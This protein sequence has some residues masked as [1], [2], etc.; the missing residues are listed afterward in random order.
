MSDIDQAIDRLSYAIQHEEDRKI[1]FLTGSGLS[2]PEV[3]S[4]KAMVSIFLNEV[5]NDPKLKERVRTLSESDQ[6]QA[7]AREV[8]RRRGD[9]GLAAA[10]GKGVLQA[11]NSDAISAGVDPESIKDTDWN[12]PVAQKLLGELF[13]QIPHQQKGAVITTNFDSLTEAS[14]NLHQISSTPLAVPGTQAFPIDAILG[15]LPI[16]HL[17][18]SWEK[19]ATLSTALELGKE[20]PDIQRMITRLLDKSILVVLGYGGWDD[21]FTRTL[22]QMIKDGHT[23]SLETEIMWLQYGPQSGIKAHPLL[24]DINGIAGINVYCEIRAEDFLKG[25]IDEVG[26][27]K[28]ASKT[29][30]LGWS[31][32]PS[33]TDNTFTKSTLL[34]YMDGAHPS[35]AS[36]QQMPM[37]DNAIDALSTVKEACSSGDSK[38]IVISGPAGEGKSTALHQV[39]M[40]LVTEHPDANIL[41]RNPAAPR[42]TP[43]WIEYVAVSSDLS[44]LFIDDA[45]L[46]FDQ[47]YQSHLALEEGTR[48]RII[49]V[50]S[51]HTSYLRSQHVQ[52]K[53]SNQNAI[54]LEFEQF[55]EGDALA[56]AEAW[57]HHSL[58]PASYA[59]YSKDAVASMI[60]DAGES[61]QGRS[62][63]GSI[64]H[65]WGGEGLYDRVN[66]LLARIARLAIAGIS[67]KH[68]L[69]A[70]AVTQVAWDLEADQGAGLSLA[71]LGVLANVTN[72][73]V[74]R[75]VV[76]P[77]GREVGISQIG[78]RVYVRHPSIANAIYD[79][80]SGHEELESVVVDI[81]RKGAAMRYSGDYTSADYACAYKIAR[82]LSGGE[83]LAASFAAVDG[84]PGRLEPRVTA[85]AVRRENGQLRTAQKYALEISKRL[86]EFA[87]HMQFQRGFYVEWAVVESRLGNYERAL[88]LAIH[89][90][91]DQVSGF[92]PLDK[93][94]YGLV[95]IAAFS[96]KLVRSGGSSAVQLRQATGKALNRVPENS[97]RFS[98]FAEL[99][100][101]SSL[102]TITREFRTAALAFAP[103]GATFRKMQEVIRLNGF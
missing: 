6:Y 23:S 20:R 96:D 24:N 60:S 28:R 17:H 100:D 39:A 45:D 14:F 67:F 54:V 5:G 86:P 31:A 21:S 68:L 9:R 65:L 49:W 79:I 38:F 3:P 93:L 77:L 44:I 82:Q 76:E 63:F 71:A 70:V 85:I 102:F 72:Q 99:G 15:P 53:L 30:P 22:T 12:L 51:M 7:A 66:D 29:V 62:L 18:G 83:A 2:A 42:I 59:D 27:L 74:V 69:S 33:S 25:V 92:L 97:D 101:N 8:Q 34:R 1:V 47:V 55:S 16:V 87:D 32:A 94:Q 103:S 26:I 35:W 52:N 48:G 88:N 36:A 75:L 81:A 95:N 4:T 56:L 89:A 10:I 40:K 41:N 98:R 78:D 57:Q 43:D 61:S 64:L 19:T 80:L 73:D 84:A 90:V 50:L 13:S 11:L 58:L 91:S 37:L 46:V